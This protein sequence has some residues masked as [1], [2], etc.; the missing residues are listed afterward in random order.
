MDAPDRLSTADILALL[1]IPADGRILAFG[2]ATAPY[3]L[4]IAAARPDVLIV[5][6]DTE[7]TTTTQIS[8]RAVAD[9][10]DN[11]IV[12]D[13]PAGPLVDRALCIDSLTTIV[14]QHLVTIRTAMLPGGYAIFVEANEPAAPPLTEKLQATGYN[15][16]DALNGALAGTTVI[17]AR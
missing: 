10:L 7:S 12:G 1:E 15:I 5:V 2:S 3:A 13:T 17:R 6:C 16:A 11:L 9:R 8:E 14:P 4:E